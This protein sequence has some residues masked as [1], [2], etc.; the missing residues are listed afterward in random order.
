M[1]RSFEVYKK[2]TVL[3]ESYRG[4]QERAITREGYEARQRVGLEA[5]WG[6]DLETLLCTEEPSS[7][8]AHG[9]GA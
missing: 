8:R 2:P 9:A 7:D 1:A 6:D 5:T 4:S 3:G